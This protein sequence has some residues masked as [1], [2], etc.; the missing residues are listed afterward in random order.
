[1]DASLS[2]SRSLLL[3]LPVYL[4]VTWNFWVH[5]CLLLPVVLS[6]RVLG[7]QLFKQGMDL[8]MHWWRGIWPFIF[9]PPPTLSRE[10]A[11]ADRVCG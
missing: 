7:S 9:C 5:L 11:S 3:L 1:M 4:T 6:L 10:V 8:W 2:P